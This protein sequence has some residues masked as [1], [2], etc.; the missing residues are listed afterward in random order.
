MP[1]SGVMNVKADALSKRH[2]SDHEWMLNNVMFSRLSKI[3][4]LTCLRQF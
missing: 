2:N 3:F 4:P 1:I